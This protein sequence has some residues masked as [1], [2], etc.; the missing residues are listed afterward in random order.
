MVVAEFV[1]GSEVSNAEVVVMFD[2]EATVPK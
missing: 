2:D 1:G